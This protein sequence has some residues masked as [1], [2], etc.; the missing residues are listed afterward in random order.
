MNYQDKDLV[1]RL[2]MEA[3]H[4]AGPFAAL[5]FEAADEIERINQYQT[6]FRIIIRDLQ[7]HIEFEKFKQEW[8][9]DDPQLNYKKVRHDLPA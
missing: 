4:G 3:T 6:A 1:Y 7:T 8:V 5:L 9:K 2:R